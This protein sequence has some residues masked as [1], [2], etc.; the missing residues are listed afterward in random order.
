MEFQYSSAFGK[1]RHG[2]PTRIR[3]SI[4]STVMRK[5]HLL[6]MTSWSRIFSSFEQN[7]SQGIN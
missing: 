7:L 2:Q 1:S 4:T 5:L 3:H 6:N